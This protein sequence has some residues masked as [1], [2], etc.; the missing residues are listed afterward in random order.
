MCPLQISSTEGL[1]GEHCRPFRRVTS[2]MQIEGER[3]IASF[4]ER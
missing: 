4:G 3:S 1:T 2:D